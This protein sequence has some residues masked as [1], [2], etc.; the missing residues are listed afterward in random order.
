S[1]ASDGRCSE[2]S[3]DS[4]PTPSINDRD[5]V[6][7]TCRLLPPRTRCRTC[8]SSA[9]YQLFVIGRFCTTTRLSV[10]TGRGLAAETGPAAGRFRSAP[11][12]AFG[13]YECTTSASSAVVRVTCHPLPPLADRWEGN[14]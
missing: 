13:M 10:A 12:S 8:I 11:P 14:W 7:E 3:V 9:S 5:R 4:R 1:A 6:Y 2:R